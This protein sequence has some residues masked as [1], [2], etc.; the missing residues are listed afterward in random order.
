MPGPPTGHGDLVVPV[1]YACRRDVVGWSQSSNRTATARPPAVGPSSE[2]VPV[3]DPQAGDGDRVYVFHGSGSTQVLGPEHL[4]ERARALLSAAGVPPAPAPAPHPDIAPRPFT[5]ESLQDP[6][7]AG[8]GAWPRERSTVSELSVGLGANQF[9]DRV[10]AGS[11]TTW[12]DRWPVAAQDPLFPP[13]APRWLSEAP[14]WELDPLAPALGPA[15]SGGWVRSPAQAWGDPAPQDRRA[16]TSRDRCHGVGLFQLTDLESFW[17]FACEPD[18]VEI[19]A[20][21]EALAATHP[22]FSWL[23]GY[24]DPR[25]V[26]GSLRLPAEC[27]PVLHADLETAGY[28]VDTWW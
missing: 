15:A 24:F 7:D 28:A 9:W 25:D 14:R 19:V 2:V 22:A 23:T 27:L 26:P 11:W 8:P 1:A 16:A 18:T 21:C 5:A 6:G 4:M 20:R 17:V 10:E 12:Q 13:S 3:F